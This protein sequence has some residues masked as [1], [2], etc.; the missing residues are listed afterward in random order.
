MNPDFVPTAPL[1]WQQPNATEFTA[2]KAIAAAHDPLL[3]RSYFAF[4]WATWIDRFRHGSA[5]EAPPAGRVAPGIQA[6]VCQHIWAL[7]HLALFQRAG[8][9]DLFWSHATQGLT[10][11]DGIRI[12][13][14]PLYPVR[15]ATHQPT[16]PMKLP[17]QR[18]L[19]YS[20][21]GAYAPGLYR[22]PVRD[23]LLALPPRPDAQLQRRR[24]WHYEQAVYREQVKG[25]CTN[26]ARHAQLALEADAYAATLQASCFALCPSG[27]GPNS[28]RLWE[29]LGYGAIPVILSD[30]LQLPGSA[31]LWQDATVLVPE[32][33]AAVAALPGQLESLAADP[34][35]LQAMQKAGQALWRRY[36]LNGCVADVV[37]LL[38]DPLAVLRA[39]AKRCLPGK[40]LEITAASPAALPLELRLCLRTAAPNCPLLI[41]ITDQDDTELLQVRWRSALQICATRIGVRPWA[42]ASIS[43]AFEA[44]A[45][46]QAERLSSNP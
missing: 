42:V 36:G 3:N 39:R 38:R 29:A 22:T 10:Q 7:E 15:C 12:H 6:T 26:A 16:Q 37:E 40:P 44:M 46:T 32:T 24:E 9:T 21:Q 14:F 23:W 20:F 41:V 18:P 11:I 33:Q 43:P 2:A 19:L 13:P 8:I 45:S 25:E 28:I 5:L 35:R 1:P 31:S 17:K 27:S 4:P 34:Q 30:Q